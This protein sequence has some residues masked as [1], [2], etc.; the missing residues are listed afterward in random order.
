[1]KIKTYLETDVWGFV[2]ARAIDAKTGRRLAVFLLMIMV[3]I[4]NAGLFVT[5]ASTITYSGDYAIITFLQTGALTVTDDT[6]YNVSFLLVGGGGGGS[7][8]DSTGGGIRTS[9]GGGGGGVVEVSNYTIT[10]AVYSVVVGAGGVS[11]AR[12]G[13]SSF[14]SYSVL[15]GGYS[16]YMGAPAGCASHGG[17]GGATGGSGGGGAAWNYI[18]KEN[19]YA[20]SAF[21]MGGGSGAF[22]ATTLVGGGGGGA[23]TNG[24]DG[25]SQPNGGAGYCTSISGT[26][27]CYGG[28]GGGGALGPGKVGG[29]GGMGGGGIGGVS[30]F[31][32]GGTGN[33]NGTNAVNGT[34]GGGG[35]N[36]GQTT[37]PT[38]GSSGGSGIV[39]LKMNISYYPQPDNAT[40]YLTYCGNET[41][42]TAVT[43]SVYDIITGSQIQYNIVSD[44]Q[45]VYNNTLLT[46]NFTNSVNDSSNFSLCIYP[47]NATA[48]AQT[49]DTITSLDYNPYQFAHQPFYYTNNTTFY[50]F[51]MLTTNESK[52]VQIYVVDNTFV[53]M[54]GVSVQIQQVNPLTSENMNLGSFLVDS[55]GTTTQALQPATQ[56]YHFSVLS[57]NGTVLQDYVNQAIPCQSTEL[58]C[59]LIL[60]VNP[61]VDIGYL[62]SF[63][64]S[65]GMCNWNNATGYLNCTSVGATITGT[66]LT[67]IHN[68]ATSYNVTCTNSISTA[69]M[70]SCTLNTTIQTCYN[71]ILNATYSN[72]E[73]K[74]LVAGEICT[75]ER[76]N[77]GQVG[78]F[79]VL[80]LVAAFT[81]MGVYFG[82]PGA[83]VGMAA[84]LTLS[85][86]IGFV[87]AIM[88][89]VVIVLDI[90][91]G[92]IAAY[93]VRG[94]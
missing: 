65:N 58:V 52:L 26:S 90:V 23:T 36:S 49:T 43:W 59:Q 6:L 5:N 1:M 64:N 70:V 48:Y 61:N 79:G 71:L 50:K 74:V 66:Q 60:I 82:A 8:A 20:G 51:Y 21:G 39:I 54:L 22:T 69:G 3:G 14:G 78:I 41:N 93:M 73:K 83:F 17:G 13:T 18:A 55:F 12:G 16:D 53:P 28:G 88:F 38:F 80:L 47:E 11:N 31:A 44:M 15:G 63:G 33:E 30:N 84:G 34:G 2:V 92:G 77:M 7:V 10:P 91:L 86:L 57:S 9:G 87:P 85:A 25:T 37:C 42:T 67:V 24:T 4:T 75:Y 27:S 76:P 62:N 46:Q 89:P 81:G 45:Q 19:G 32:T 29:A 94:A 56:I 35:G 72:S 68:N 40:G